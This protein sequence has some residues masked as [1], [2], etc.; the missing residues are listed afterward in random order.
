[1][2]AHGRGPPQE[3]HSFE[4]KA[5]NS[6]SCHKSSREQVHQKLPLLGRPS[7]AHLSLLTTWRRGRWGGAVA[8]QV[9]RCSGKAGGNGLGDVRLQA[10][11]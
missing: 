11:V 4:G 8:R 2:R 7:A 5:P 3:E 10:G 6:R 1:M 9:G